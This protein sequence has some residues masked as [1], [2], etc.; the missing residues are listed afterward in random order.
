[1]VTFSIPGDD[2]VEATNGTP[3]QPRPPLPFAKRAYAAASPFGGAPGKR[4]GTPHSSS[5]RK[6]LMTRDEVPSS[7]LNKSSIATAR[8][9]FRASAI[10][11]S[12]PTSTFS[13]SIP[14]STMKR[15]FAP[16][17]TPEPSRVYRETVAHATPRGMAAKT[18]TKELFP[19]RISSPPPELSGEV[20]TQ[21]VPKEWNSKGSIYADQFLAHLCPP[22]LD[23]EQRRQFFCILD[24]RRL[25]YAANEIFAK[26]DWKLNVINFAK[27]F[28]K[29][30]SIILL[31]YGLY[32]FQNVKP[33]REVL[34]R[35]RREHGLPEPEDEEESEST[36]SKMTASKKRK[37]AEDT[38]ETLAAKGK[39]RVMDKEPEPEP[40]V[41]TPAASKNKRKA[42]VSDEQPTK[43]HKS[44]PSSAKSLFEKIA[45][46]PSSKP[47]D[48]TA[49]AAGPTSAPKP[50]LYTANKPTTSSSLAR[51]VFTNLKPTAA[52]AAASPAS[53]SNIFGYL[54]DASSAKNSGVD[55]DAESES[56]S[57][58]DD[59][60]E[61]GQSDEP[62]VAASGA[63]DT[64]SQLGSSLFGKKPALPA[65]GL[66]AGFASAPD[67][68]ESTPGRS[69]FERVTKGSD[70][71]PVRA[72]ERVD[73]V[74]ERSTEEPSAAADQTWNP[75]TTPIKFAP[76]AAAAPTSSFFGNAT[77]TS[78][79]S[80][81]A[82]KSGSATS[83]IFGAA[84]QDESGRE[85][86]AAASTASADKNGGE[87]DKENDSQP[88]KKAL[89][90]SNTP[91]AQPSFGSSLF[92]LKP[93]VE[94]S[95]GTGTSTPATSLV[96]SAPNPDA[97]PAE[98]STTNNLFGQANKTNGTAGHHITQSTTLFGA[99]PTEPAKAA[100][101]EAPKA[102]ASLFGGASSGATAT[103]NAGSL[104][105]AGAKPA[106]TTGSLFGSGA[107]TP[108]QQPLFGA[109]SAANTDANAPKADASKPIFNFGGAS[110][111]GDS[112]P[113]SDSTA[114][115][116]S[117]FGGPKS[118]PAGSTSNNLFGSPMK[119][120]DPSPAKKKTFNGGSNGGDS[121]PVF[122]FGGGQTSAQT[123]NLFGASTAPAQGN[124]AA[125]SGPTSFGGAGASTSNSAGTGGFNFS[126]G[127]AG[128][129]AAATSGATGGAF[130]NPFASG[131]SGSNA[132]A[133]TAAPSSGGLFNFGA[134]SSAPGSGT[135][136]PFQF[137]GGNNASIPTGGM[138][139]GGN[140]AANA[141]PMFGGTSGSSN[142]FN[143]SAGGSAPQGTGSVF[144]SNQAAA[145]AFNLQPP[146]GGST[147]TGT[148]KSPF[149]HR[150]I[151]PLKR[152]V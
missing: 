6:L 41:A 146:T 142:A 122:G 87:S 53:S 137:G 93:A 64:G 121:T 11:D 80:L 58:Q 15:V 31:R 35:W 90:G 127:G 34:K 12:P 70:G 10:T 59:S 133:P 23:E 48:E 27:E 148:S 115:A 55:A 57:D 39:R 104:F 111:G 29:S 140:Q 65:S 151:A 103:G 2:V 89:L 83:N 141:A 92:Q 110:A 75:S 22:E 63:G 72:E 61:A 85:S 17:A 98:T 102:A 7:S 42:S 150:K 109:T 60:Q 69:L 67:T 95:K 131:N 106:S 81:F 47:A 125:G 129:G 78:S 105:G 45:N 91:A 100:D 138:S 51:S 130:N 25:K 119:Q 49:S 126:F 5:T 32:E 16:G 38:S 123:S 44:T 19:M 132:G 117:L 21:G 71:Q 68:R 84:K 136:T 108:A 3:R 112:K 88:A 33:S 107:S 114:P 13:P 79:S 97:K 37:A 101:A 40:V 113:A 46:K 120:D 149:P 8:N 1:M 139:F 96:G 9:I 43:L 99:K 118:P 52:Q 144:G 28:E 50:S 94:A 147:T 135:S 74:S 20:L 73:E 143:F 36:P 124:S 26:K 66:G 152:R 116:K 145:P 86:S 18:T 62:S 54:S 14:Q 76:P 30:R 56:D 82:P 4:M 128:A 24:L 134:G 77:T